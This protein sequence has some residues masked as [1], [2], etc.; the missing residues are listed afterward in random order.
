VVMSEF[1]MTPTGKIRR[2]ELVQK[3]AGR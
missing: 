1:P 2:P 3:V